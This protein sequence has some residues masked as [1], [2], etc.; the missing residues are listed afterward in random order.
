[1]PQHISIII[2][3]E[4]RAILA[5]ATRDWS[6]FSGLGICY[7]PQLVLEELEFLTKRAVSETDEKTA[8]E[9]LRFFPDSGW[10]VTQGMTHHDSLTGMEGEDMSKNARL[11]LA[12]A[13]SIYYLSLENPHKLVILV[14]NQ[15]SLR[16]EVDN[17]G[18]DNLISLTL[19]QFIQWL[20]T[21]QKPINVSQKIAS[22]SN[23][24]VSYT[25]PANSSL[26]KNIN[27]NGKGVS[28][29]PENYSSKTKV[30]TKNKNNTL[31]FTISGLL[32]TG[33]LIIT[34]MVVW[35]FIQPKSF[36]KFWEK[37]GLP[38]LNN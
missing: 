30:K 23:G 8:R 38:T 6:Q 26:V 20:R 11:Q 17:L 29:N 37:T 31:S 9:F 10:Q 7:I 28:K 16:E 2:V 22:L 13:E 4:L 36:Q 1:M 12:I 18:Q 27:N 21:Q 19:P 32:A 3:F 33:G 35:Y 14:A 24:N 5:G 25:S 15:Q 34:M